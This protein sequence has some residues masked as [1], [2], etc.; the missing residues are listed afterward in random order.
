MR[1]YLVIIS[2]TLLK[3]ISGL[4]VDP[5][6]DCKV[7]EPVNGNDSVENVVKNIKISLQNAINR[8]SNRDNCENMVTHLQET[9]RTAE[10][11]T[12]QSDKRLFVIDFLDHQGVLSKDDT[13]RNGLTSVL[14]NLTQ[15]G[16]RAL[17]F[18][19]KIEDKLAS[20]LYQ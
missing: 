18:L 15:L 14:P 10:G 11:Q 19:K 5:E 4:P 3:F 8:A 6:Y 9:L 16:R 1:Y 17:N 13:R 2:L 7:L 20:V 12:S